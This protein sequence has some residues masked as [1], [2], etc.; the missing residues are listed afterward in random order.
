MKQNRLRI[1]YKVSSL[2]DSKLDKA[3]TETLEK[4]GWKFYGSGAD[5]SGKTNERDLAFE[6]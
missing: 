3:L 2:V 6:R 5:V 4:L 1:E